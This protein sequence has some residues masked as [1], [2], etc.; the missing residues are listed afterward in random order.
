M[1]HIAALLYGL[2]CVTDGELSFR[3]RLYTS[4]NSKLLLSFHLLI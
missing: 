4:L 1:N 3:E 2:G